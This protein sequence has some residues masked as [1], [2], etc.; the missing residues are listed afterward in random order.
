[1]THGPGRVDEQECLNA[2]PTWVAVIN[3]SIAYFWPNRRH[4]PLTT[5][6]LEN[7]WRRIF[8]LQTDGFGFGPANRT[9]DVQNSLGLGLLRGY[10]QQIIAS[11][12][13]PVL[14]Y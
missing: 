4:R 7:K 9:L 6:S 1:M 11:A 5:G 2:A 13:T 14:R 3:T 12:S 8:G 10:T